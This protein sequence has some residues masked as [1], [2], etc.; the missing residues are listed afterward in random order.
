MTTNSRSGWSGFAF[1]F[2][3]AGT[4]LARAGRRRS[5]RSRAFSGSGASVL[6]STAVCISDAA[7]PQY[8]YDENVWKIF[9]ATFCFIDSDQNAFLL[10]RFRIGLLQ[11][12][13]REDVCRVEECREW[14]GVARGFGETMIEAAVA[15]TSDVRVDGVEDLPIFFIGVEALIDE[16]TQE[17]SR[18]RDAESQSALDRYNVVALV[19]EIDARSRTAARPRPMTV[20]FCVR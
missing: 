13:E 4:D 6:P 16:V 12:G 9:G 7:R 3:S 20:G 19:F 10:A 17:A 2:C 18:L 8:S 14:A 5:N 15:S 11:V 1:D